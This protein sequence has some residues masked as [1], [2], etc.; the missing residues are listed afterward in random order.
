ML[1]ELI[2]YSQISFE[3][4]RSFQ[5]QNRQ[6]SVAELTG[7]TTYNV[8]VLAVNGA[9]DGLPAH[10]VVTTEAGGKTREVQERER[11]GG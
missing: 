11:E 1:T 4:G 3:G 7:G 6:F 8:S 9:G 5:T 2:F 10:S